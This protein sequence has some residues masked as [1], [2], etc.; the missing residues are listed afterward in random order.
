MKKA[1]QRISEYLAKR[2]RLLFVI[3]ASGALITAFFLGIV[4]TD[5]CACTGM[6]QPAL[7]KLFIIA[8]LLSAYSVSCLWLFKNIRA[9]F[10]QLIAVANLLYSIATLS[11]LLLYYPKLSVM[12]IAYFL[13]E[14]LIITGLAYLEFKVAAKI[15][16]S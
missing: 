6:P 3:D 15:H 5:Y 2:P 11:L 16:E 8:L 7:R 12:G 10:I 9:F 1:V 13:T 4:W 14:L